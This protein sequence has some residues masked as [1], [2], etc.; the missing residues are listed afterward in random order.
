MSISDAHTLIP[1][2][3]RRK[4]IAFTKSPLYAHTHTRAH[5]HTQTDLIEMN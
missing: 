4:I 5:T 2:N 1:S 3:G